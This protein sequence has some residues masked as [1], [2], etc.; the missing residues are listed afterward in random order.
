MKRNKDKER[1][2]KRYL[3]KIEINEEMKRKKKNG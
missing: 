3:E 2:R 1:E